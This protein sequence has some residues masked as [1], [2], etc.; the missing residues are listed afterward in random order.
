MKMGK[1]VAEAASERET[2]P[3]LERAVARR[4]PGGRHTCGDLTT[5]SALPDVTAARFPL[6]SPPTVSHPHIST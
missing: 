1:G 6:S 4:A 5:T 2:Q 3:D